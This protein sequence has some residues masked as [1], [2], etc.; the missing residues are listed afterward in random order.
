[1]PKKLIAL[2]IL[3]AVFSMSCLAAQLKFDRRVQ[4]EM[5]T[6]LTNP[7]ENILG[8]IEEWNA[9][10]NL[11][12]GRMVD[13]ENVQENVLRFEFINKRGLT[14][15]WYAEGLDFDSQR[16]LCGQVMVIL[17][18]LY[19]QIPEQ[20]RDVITLSCNLD[21]IENLVYIWKRGDDSPVINSDRMQDFM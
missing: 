12:K 7:S 4:A 14:K 5:E 17:G 2:L 15:M 9:Q 21:E 10:P 16:I 3:L 11:S 18:S 6:L 1:M 20:K 8:I 19:W 13:L